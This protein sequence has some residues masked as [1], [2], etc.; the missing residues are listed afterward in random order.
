VAVRIREGCAADFDTA[1]A[2]FVESNGARRK[3]VWPHQQSSVERLQ[4]CLQKP[5]SSL[6]VAEDGAA[7]VGMASAEPMRNNDGVGAVVPG[8][9]FLGYLYVVPQRWGEGIGGILLDAVLAD[10][11]QRQC[12]RI[13]LWTH[14]DNE[15]S[16]R[17]YRS[18]GFRPTGCHAG[19]E[20]EWECQIPRADLLRE[21]REKP[22]S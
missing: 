8:G 13:R 16:H 14:D 4:E 12:F 11:R 17:L 15:R 7:L 10:A 22:G 6:L 3:G 5:D 9:R 20:C 18:H 21:L 2:V 19:S 1:V